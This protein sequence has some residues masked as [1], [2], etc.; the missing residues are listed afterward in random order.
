MR[1]LALLFVITLSGVPLSARA[2]I[3]WSSS[4]AHPDEVRI[5]TPELT[6]RWFNGTA[7]HPVVKL[8]TWNHPDFTTT[9][10]TTVHIWARWNG[11]YINVLTMLL[12]ASSGGDP[13][14]GSGST[15]AN[16][17]TPLNDFYYRLNVNSTSSLQENTIPT[18][19]GETIRRGDELWTLMAPSWSAY[20]AN[21]WVGSSGSLPYFE[22]CEGSCVNEPPPPP[23]PCA[24]PGACASNVLF[25]PGIEA[26]RLYARNPD[27]SEKMFWEPGGDSDAMALA[28]NQDG[29]VARN[30]LYTRDVI[31]NA[32]VPFKGNVYKSFL[33]QLNTMKNTDRTIADYAVAPYD[34][35]LSFDEVLNAGAKMPDGR[36]YYAGPLGA[37]TTPYI[38]Q[39]LRRLAIN[40][41]TGKVT[42]V[43]H[44]NG[45]LLAKALTNKL[46]SDAAKLIDKIIFVAVPQ[47]GTPQAVGAI[48]HG[49]EQALPVKP[50]SAFGMTEAAA[51]ELARNM[52]SVYNLLP[53]ANYFTYTDDPVITM[54]GDPLLAPWRAA[55]GETIHSGERLRTFLTDQSRM[56]LPVADPLVSPIVANGVL[57]QRSETVHSTLDSW[58]PPTG[59]S[60]Y[61]IAGWGEETLSTIHYYQGL[62][63]FCTA[64]KADSTCVA[65]VTTPV[66]QYSP[67]MVLDG[68]GTVVVPSALWT[69]GV[70]KYW[71]DLLGYGSG[72]FGTTINRKHADILE[73]PQLRTF[74]Q[75]VITGSATSTPPEFILTEAPPN[76][77]PEKQLHFTLHSPLSLDLYDDRGNH[78]G[79]STT[80]HSLEE[81]IPNSRYFT[82]GEVQF[83]RVP[84]SAD[85]RLIMNGKAEGSFT[86]DLAEVEGDTV[87]A[88]TTFAAVPS[89]IGTVVTM[90]VPAGAD[91]ADALLLLVDENGDGTTDLSLV[92][93]PG[94]VVVPD[95]A[96]PETTAAPTGALGAHG[97]YR[98]SVSVTLS[99]TDEG[100]GVKETL[101]SLD[102]GASW[103]LYNSPFILDE[104][105]TTIQYYSTD[106][107]GNVETVQSLTIKIDTTAPE[108]VLAFSPTTGDIALTGRD[109]LSPV[110]VMAP[111]TL[112]DEAGN[113]TILAMDASKRESKNAKNAS[114][115]ASLSVISYAVAATIPYSF[116]PNAMTY[117]W[118]TDK[119]PAFSNLEQKIQV[120]DVIIQALS[121]GAKSDETKIIV[122]GELQSKESGL[123]L[124]RLVTNKGKLDVE[125]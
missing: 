14:Y 65:L 9:A 55:Y 83:I 46:G 44:S 38:I 36:L 90:S 62:K 25:L 99:A 11:V 107:A 43:A 77:H 92:S 20:G 13:F 54:S 117:G 2:S 94:E 30:D 31:D 118:Q 79:M 122:N 18:R 82:F 1:T 69:P 86:L 104:G 76:P 100:S 85:V 87:L 42:I 8:G 97:W 34:W 109:N 26:S 64:R 95:L 72:N 80:T 45:G 110:T 50:L 93:K 63:S 66:L 96:P 12:R 48:L 101:Y 108:A 59:I 28:M 41:K 73:V 57:L 123:V 27:G 10:S 6:N 24:A 4:A 32:Y 51:R 49:F 91:I 114:M 23:D 115:H 17:I 125:Y 102:S 37:T 39:E 47:A 29:T 5:Y 40:S 113:T 98:S 61:E 84:V 120:G 119:K 112:T 88:T 22:I 124:L 15:T 58:V 71:V 33:E 21:H 56:V 67:K 121:T 74:I 106:S 78:T 3:I 60:L 81:N 116:P 16:V 19:R 89:S 68:D 103:N 75:S 35:R 53:S 105:I 111:Y 7:A 52:P 70:Q